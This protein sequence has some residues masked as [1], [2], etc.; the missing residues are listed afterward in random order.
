MIFAMVLITNMELAILRMN[1]KT[2]VERPVDHALKAMECVV[3]SLLDVEIPSL[4]T[5]PIL[6][7]MEL[8]LALVT[9]KFADATPIFAKC[10]W[11]LPPFK[12]LDHPLQPLQL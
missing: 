4:K 5:V 6:R 3:H 1:V 7:A 11:T 8:A 9:L 12:F 10:V 2:R